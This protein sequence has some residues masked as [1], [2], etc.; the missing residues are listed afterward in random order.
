MSVSS[1]TTRCDTANAAPLSGVKFNGDNLNGANLT[2]NNLIG[3][4][5]KGTSVVGS[6]GANTICPDGTNSNADG[7]TCVGNL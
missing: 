1:T 3:A 2:G 7:N 6:I 4:N 5:L